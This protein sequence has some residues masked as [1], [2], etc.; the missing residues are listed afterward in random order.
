M[1]APIGIHVEANSP[2]YS[3]DQAIQVAKR[4]GASY[5]TIVNDPQLCMMMLDI[6]VT[7]IHR[8]NREGL[9]DDNQDQYNTT[10]LYIQTAAIEAPDKRVLIH[11]DNEP[12]NNMPRLLDEGLIAVDEAVRLGRTLVMLNFSYGNPEPADHELL[13][14]LY[15]RMAETGMIYGCHEGTDISHPTLASCYPS[16]IGRFLPIQRKYG[17]RVIVT[18]FAASKDAWNGYATWDSNFAAVC[19]DTVRDVYSPNGVAMTPFT[20]FEWKTGFAYI[21]DIPLQLSWAQTN[22]EFPL[23]VPPLPLPPPP[24]QVV[25]PPVP[26][27][28]APYVVASASGLKHRAAPSLSAATLRV[29]ANGQRVTGYP[30]SQV[31]RDGYTWY[32]CVTQAGENG[33]SANSW[34]VPVLPPEVWTVNLNVPF[35]SQQGAGASLSANDCGLAAL[36]SMMRYAMKRKGFLQPDLPTVDDVSRHTALVKP[37]PPNGLTIGDVIAIGKRYGVECEYVQPM[38]TEAIIDYLDAGK[39]VMCLVDYSKFNPSGEKISHYVTVLGYSANAFLCHD[40]YL[41]G[42]NVTIPQAQLAT[43]M[44]ITPGNSIGRQSMVLKAA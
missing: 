39:P 6:G 17:F 25:V 42:A 4:V 22:K 28:P 43:A 24:V 11:W 44:L 8:I 31:V 29:L 26:G 40:S 7:P 38:T 37:N 5:A 9:L 23:S 41:L 36:L 20:T 14:P 27:K 12:A 15:R 19:R 1:T 10:R 21:N 18:E 3:R 13:A 33:W 16:L 34:L 32:Y 2:G 30:D 35:V